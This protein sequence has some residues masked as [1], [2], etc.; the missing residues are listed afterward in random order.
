MCY[1]AKYKQEKTIF[2]DVYLAKT[3]VTKSSSS[4]SRKIEFSLTLNEYKRL[5]TRK[6]CQYSGLRMHGDGWYQPT[7]ERVDN[8]IGYVKGNVIAVCYGINNFKSIIEATSNPITPEIVQKML[9]VM[10]RNK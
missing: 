10:S 8:N 7:L 6:I 4:R 5:R 9:N 2:A 3:Y 1:C